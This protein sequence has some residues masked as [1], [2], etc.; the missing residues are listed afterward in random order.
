[1]FSAQN[2]N[3]K[4]FVLRF[5]YDNSPTKLLRRFSG[6]STIYYVTPSS[7][8]RK[9]YKYININRAMIEIDVAVYG[10]AFIL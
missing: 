1:M 8:L 3:D 10:N 5:L 7:L 9:Y 2:V 4:L 6:N